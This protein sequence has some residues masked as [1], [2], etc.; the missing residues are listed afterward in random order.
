MESWVDSEP[1][2]FSLFNPP[3]G[4]FSTELLP[5]RFGVAIGK[6]VLDFKSLVIESLL[7]H[8]NIDWSQVNFATLN[9]Y[10]ALGRSRHRTIRKPLRKSLISD[11]QRGSLLR[12]H[13][14][15]RQCLL[16]LRAS[17]TTHLPM[18]IGVYTDFFV[19]VHYAKM[20]VL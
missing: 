2:G 5:P 11:T 7:A 13:P 17:V 4:I 15:R 12:D 14:Q 6:Y 18:R 20:F 1:S 16:V 8:L 9:N 3:L 10:A 19:G